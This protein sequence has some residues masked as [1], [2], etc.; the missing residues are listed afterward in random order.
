[1]TNSRAVTLRALDPETLVAH[2]TLELETDYA[3]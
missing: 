1:M 3:V 2:A